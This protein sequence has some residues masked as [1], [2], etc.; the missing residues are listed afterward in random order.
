MVIPAFAALKQG[1]SA[2]DFTAKA[3][4]AGKEFDF[5]LESALKKGP[6]YHVLYPSA[7]TGGCDIEAH[8]FAENSRGKFDAAGASIIGVSRDGIARLND[9]SADPQYMRG[10]DCCGV[11]HRRS[12]RQGLRPEQVRGEAGNEGLARAGDI[13]H[14]FT[15]RTTFVVRQFL[16][17][18]ATL[19]SADDKM[20]AA[21]V[22][23][24]LA[25]VQQFAATKSKH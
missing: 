24:S 7:F 22:E 6:V 13:D 3:S 5:S 1:D 2:P 9:F 17:I 18:L 8:T 11:R 21:H 16:Q 25:V 19:S 10:Q 4:L 23:K 20:T 15:E 14:D 12:D